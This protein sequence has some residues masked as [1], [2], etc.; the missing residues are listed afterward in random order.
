MYRETI[1]I[2]C[3][4]ILGTLTIWM[5][6][7][8]FGQEPRHWRYW[9]TVDG[10]SESTVPYISLSP[11]GRLWCTHGSPV[12]SISCMDGYGISNI[13]FV[14]SHRVVHESRC[15]QLWS[16]Y[17]NGVLLYEQGSWIPFEIEGFDPSTCSILS[18]ATDCVL[19]LSPDRLVEYN[20]QKKQSTLIKTSSETKI[21][22]FNE[23]ISSRDGGIWLAGQHGVA[24]V[25]NGNHPFSEGCEWKE[26][27]LEADLKLQNLFS[28]IE[29]DDGTLYATTI[30]NQ[31]KRYVLV[32][33]EDGNWRVIYSSEEEFDAGWPDVDGNL[34]LLNFDLHYL[35]INYLTLWNKEVIDN[36]E[37]KFPSNNTEWIY[38]SNHSFWTKT[39]RNVARYASPAWRTPP[40]LKNIDTYINTIYEDPLGRIWL[41][42][43]NKLIMIDGDKQ[44][45]YTLPN[46]LITFQH[47]SV[48]ISYLQSGHIAIRTRSSVIVLFSPEDETFQIVRH[49]EG[50][51]IAAIYAHKDGHIWVQLGHWDSF[52]LDIYDGHVFHTILEERDDWNMGELRYVY[53]DDNGD[54]WLGGMNQE[55]IG[56]YH[57]GQYHTFGSDYPGNAAMCILRVDDDRIWFTDRN[58]IFEYDGKNWS[59]VYENID[60]VHSMI[61]S[62]DGSVWVAAWSGLYRYYQDSWIQITAK[63]GLP[64]SDAMEVFEDSQGNIWVSTLKGI[65]KFNPNSDVSPPI[66]WMVE[67]QNSKTITSDGNAQF[68]FEGIDKWKQTQKER[69]LY[70]YRID[71]GEWSEFQSGNV[72]AFKAI[73]PGR[74]T[75]QVRASDLN[76]NVSESPAI[77]SFQVMYPWYR[78][79]KVLLLM[80][81]SL[82]LALLFAGIAVNRHLKLNRYSHRLKISNTQLNN[83]NVELQQVNAQLI[84]L[85]QMKSQFVSQA[86]HDLRTPLTAI[87]GSLDNLL[88]GIAGDLNEKQQK[89]MTRATNSVDRLTNL[90]N[91][92]LDLNRIETGRIVLEKTNVPFGSL[93]ENSI[94]ENKPAA[95]QKRIQLTANLETDPTIHADAG[96]LERVVGELISNAIKYT[97]EGGSVEVSLTQSDDKV[98]LSVKDSGIGMTKEECEKIWERFYRTNASKTFAKGSGLGLSIAKEL[99]EM[100]GGK[101]EVESE[102]GKG[103]T[104]TMQMP[105]AALS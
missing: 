88:L 48:E 91:D 20:T 86:S 45:S 100:H 57:D 18:S 60:Q 8:A 2:L 101:L 94:N 97:S 25:C 64:T 4:A 73:A 87:K 33:F 27:L 38:D 75:F 14:E 65:S 41:T 103:S 9:T 67:G 76:W 31:Q 11:S 92:V 85:D 62:R 7:S 104:F 72:A 36:K 34:W 17:S 80:S 15:N 71:N 29:Y 68:V 74:H 39:S 6:L 42:T 58:S 50:K 54:I 40:A 51:H 81:L 52:Q 66:V 102:V 56:R 83:M 5:N 30:S 12:A 32:H 95:E 79:T 3:F 90:I 63:E 19:I 26:Y 96:K 21:G 22:L 78:D 84:Q 37:I 59:T 99:V 16:C 93:V 13:P 89:I 55:R 82:F 77:H 1:C 23:M 49:P 47:G 105:F 35:I 46:N 98:I 69:L 70:S 10:L 24:R 53:E 43:V 61:K 44:K 28:L